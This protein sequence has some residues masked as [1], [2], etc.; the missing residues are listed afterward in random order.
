MMN[1]INN[2]F[3]QAHS[4]Y[5]VFEKNVMTKVKIIFFILIAPSKNKKIGK[6][7]CNHRCINKLAYLFIFKYVLL[8]PVEILGPFL[9]S[10]NIAVIN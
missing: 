5:F 10:F 6:Q 1:F 2:S 8:V 7:S 4:C 3:E 9:T